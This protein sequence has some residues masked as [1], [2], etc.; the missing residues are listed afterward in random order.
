MDVTRITQSQQRD[1]VSQK[2]I[3]PSAGFALTPPCVTFVT[4]AR[5]RDELDLRYALFYLGALELIERALSI[6][7]MAVSK[8]RAEI[9]LARWLKP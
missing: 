4:A 8:T 1:Y 5:T 2:T 6:A 7:P 9:P 3:N